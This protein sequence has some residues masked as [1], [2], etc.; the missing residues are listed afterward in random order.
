MTRKRPRVLVREVALD[1]LARANRAK[2]PQHR[3]ALLGAAAFAERHGRY[4]E[5]VGAH[6]GR[7]AGEEADAIRW[8]LVEESRTDESGPYTLAGRYVDKHPDFP[9]NS[10][11]AKIKRLVRRWT[12]MRK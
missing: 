2:D 7:Y 12:K 1:F 4:A 11:E 10:R 8:M 9:G 6:K 3:Q 5:S